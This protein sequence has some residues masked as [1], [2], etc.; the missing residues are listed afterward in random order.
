MNRLD[1]SVEITVVKDNV[2]RKI[3]LPFICD[4][5]LWFQ[6]LKTVVNHK[7]EIPTLHLIIDRPIVEPVP[8]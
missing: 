3:N 1:H 7:V 6:M 2:E 4:D 8:K 5:Q